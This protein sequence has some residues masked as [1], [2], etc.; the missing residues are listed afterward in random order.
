MEEQERVLRELVLPLLQWYQENR[1]DLP[2]RRD[3]NP[4]HIWV[5]EV[6]LQQTRVAAVVGYFARFMEA[7]PTVADLADAP[8]DELLKLWQGLGYYAR[9][10]NLQKAA[11]EIVERYGGGLPAD[12][13]A[14]RALPGFGD[15]TAGAVAS[16]A[17][18]LSV[19]A[20][21]GNVLRV[22]ARL[23][24][25][26]RDIGQSATKAAMR[27]LL[28]RVIPREAPGEFN[29]A[30]MELGAIVC[31]PNGAPLCDRCPL[32]TSC[33]AL[34]EGRIG[35]LPVKGAKKERRVEQRT[36][37]LIFSGDR[38]A[39]RRR[40][41]RGLLARLWEYPNALTGDPDPL[42]GWGVE[43]V[44]QTNACKGKHIFTHIEWRMQAVAVEVSDRTQLPEGWVWARAWELERIYAL[45][46][47]FRFVR[48]DVERRLL[49]GGGVLHDL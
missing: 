16:I 23:L 31:L 20:V 49:S 30:L 33:A 3:K 44:S 26:E 45:P 8:E 10:R 17:F 21:D 4:Y 40:P 11:R 25:D 6:M 24:G 36:V 14:L 27:E 41:E 47:A 28:L 38:V 37:Y 18:G 43:K 22:L 35:E 34:R 19:P 9:A 5:S 48:D 46:N 15:Y 32:R 29:Q 7:L 39:L 2:W 1:R 42:P 13:D 12:Y